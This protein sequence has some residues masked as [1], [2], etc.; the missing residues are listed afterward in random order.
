M[1]LYQ[2][3]FIYAYLTLIF[4]CGFLQAIGCIG[5]L[6]L[7]QKLLTTYWTLLLVLMIGDVFIGFIWVIRLDGIK[8]ELRPNLKQRLSSQYGMN[9]YFTHTWDW[10]QQKEGCCGVDGPKDYL[11]INGKSNE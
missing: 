1:E 10:V 6:R 3:T 8:S 2:P 4:Q 7:N 5:A 11:R 9:N